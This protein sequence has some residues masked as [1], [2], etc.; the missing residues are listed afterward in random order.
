MRFNVQLSLLVFFLV[1]LSCTDTLHLSQN[2]GLNTY[3]AQIVSTELQDAD[4]ILP[5]RQLLD[6]LETVFVFIFTAEL[7]INLFCRW[8]WPFVKNKWCIFDLVVVGIS[9]IS[10][11]PVGL[12]FSLLLLFR[13]CRV[14]RVVGRFK[15]VRSIFSTLMR[16]FNSMASA[17]FLIFL[18]SSICEFKVLHTDC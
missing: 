17:F 9:L 6:Q 4:G 10:L 12:P 18:L 3:S 2:F 8:F 1:Q 5:T 13:C 15:T 11:A 16:S 14:L 7:G